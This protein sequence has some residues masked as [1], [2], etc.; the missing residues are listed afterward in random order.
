MSNKINVK[1]FVLL[2]S[3]AAAL[4]AVC[5]IQ[6]SS[7]STTITDS[8]VIMNADDD[9]ENETAIF[10]YEEEATG[11][12]MEEKIAVDPAFIFSEMNRTMYATRIVDLKVEPKDSSDSS[13]NID[14]GV[15]IQVVGENE[16]GYL[17][18]LLDGQEWYIK[19]EGLTEN[20]E[21]IFY[22]TNYV[23][24]APNEIELYENFDMGNS[25]GTISQ[26]EELRVIGENGL[27]LYIVQSNNNE[28]YI[29]C[30]ELLEYLPKEAYMQLGDDGVTTY[31][32]NNM[33]DGVLAE[34]DASQQTEENVDM[35]ARL[36]FCEAGGQTDAGMLAVATVVVN[37][38]YDGYWG[39]SVSSVINAPGQFT[40][41]MTGKVNNCNPSQA[42]YDAAR[43]VLLDGYR[44][45]PAYVMYFQSL[46]DGYF[47][48]NTYCVCRDANGNAPQ[49]FSYTS[50]DL[51]KYIR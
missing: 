46:S 16:F 3:S 18:I 29:Q 47:G 34:V 5:A 31:Y 20:K 19:N 51:N 12:I 42:A 48:D 10:D 4:A 8:V 45:F 2:Y 15:E 41:A 38:M 21:E 14:K 17:K 37:R 43:K 24:Y 44:S 32:Q 11:E 1:K 27:G 13:G 25:I 33:Y 30:D 28:G 7:E 6:E 9:I 50:R 22:D 49:Y 35:L 36:V 26:Y 39:N 40:P 23:R